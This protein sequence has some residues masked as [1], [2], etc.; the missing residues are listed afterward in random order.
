MGLMGIHHPDTLCHFNGLTHCPWCGNKGQK[1]GTVVKHLRTVHY[2]LGLMC[3]KCF[4][5]PS[6]T[7]ETIWG[8]GWKNCQPSA[9]G[10]P[11][12][13]SSSA[14]PLACSML[15]QPSQ[16]RNLDGGSKGRIWYL[17]GHLIEDTPNPSVLTQKEDQTKELSPAN[18]ICTYHLSL[19]APGSDCCCH[20][21]IQGCLPCSPKMLNFTNV[22]PIKS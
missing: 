19:P 20:P 18:L 22:K 21:W 1:E 7:S 9:E 11:N 2:K 3:E 4:C 17:L 16:D 10:G 13:S 15:D 12:E 8:H 6:I 14:W 5:C